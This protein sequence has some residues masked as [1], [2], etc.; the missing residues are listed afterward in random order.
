[1]IETSQ[2]TKYYY[3]NFGRSKPELNVLV[4]G[5]TLIGYCVAIFMLV[6]AFWLINIIGI[7]LLFHTL[8]LSAYLSH[9]CAHRTIFKKSILNVWA[10]EV[11]QWLNGSCYC[12]FTKLSKIHLLHH[13]EKADH[14][15]LEYPNLLKSLPRIVKKLI[16]LLEWL[17]FPILFFILQWRGI[18]APYWCPSRQAERL[19]VSIILTI[20]GALFVLLGAISPKAL[21]LYFIC[22]LGMVTVIRMMDAF[23]HDYEY[24]EEGQV[25]V[26]REVEYERLHTFSVLTGRFKW[27][28]LLIMNFGYH[29]A[30]HVLISCPWYNLPKLHDEIC[31]N[32]EVY[33][34]NLEKLL[35]Y[36]HK[37]RIKRIFMGEGEFVINSSREI[38]MGKF[39]GVLAG[40]SISVPGELIDSGTEIDAL[41]NRR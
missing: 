23:E 14:I 29:N 34:V 35:I 21:C 15:D 36:Y 22:F 38:D 20:R 19:R 37:H 1:M 25:A 33:N 27:L 41:L 26:K 13:I 39:Y 28:N 4:I 10:G 8:I 40:T 12:P 32:Q 11:F 2:T 9:E 7:I 5:Y 6:S 16:F 3:Q 30:H 17:Y 18:T 24:L 31:Q